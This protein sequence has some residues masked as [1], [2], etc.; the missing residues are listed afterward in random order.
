MDENLKNRDFS[1]NKTMVEIR[2]FVV[3]SNMEYDQ[4]YK[5]SHCSKVD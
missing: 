5:L 4:G 2:Y 3:T 1:K